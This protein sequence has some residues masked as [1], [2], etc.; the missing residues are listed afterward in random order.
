MRRNPLI[1]VIVLLAGPALAIGEPNFVVITLQPTGGGD[2]W[3]Y[4]ISDGHVVGE[5]NNRATL[6]A[7]LVDPVDLH[8]AGFSSSWA[9]GIS[10]GKQVGYGNPDGSTDHHALLWSGTPGSVVDLHPAGFSYSSARGISGDRQAGTG[11]LDGDSNSHALLWSGTPESVVDLHPAGFSHSCAYSISGDRQAGYGRLDGDSNNHALLWSGTPGSVVDLHPAGFSYSSA[12]GISGDSQAGLGLLDGDNNSHALLWSGTPESVVDLHPAGFRSSIATAISGAWQAGSGQKEGTSWYR[13]LF[14]S[15]TAES[16]VNLHSFVDEQYTSSQAYG[17]DS[18]GNVAGYAEIREPP[19]NLPQRDVLLWWAGG[20][21]TMR[22]LNLGKQGIHKRSVRIDSPKLLLVSNSLTVED[23][24]SVTLDGGSVAVGGTFHI[25]S[26]GSLSGHGVVT[27]AILGDG[28]SVI[29]ASGDTLELGDGNRLDGFSTSGRLEVGS[30]TVSLKSLSFSTLGSVTTLEGGT[31]Q[32]SKGLFLSGGGN[33]SGYGCINAMLA[34]GQGSNILASGNLQL[35][36]A[37]AFNGVDLEGA[38]TIGSHTVTLDDRNEA[39][40]GWHT[41]IGGGCLGAPNGLLLREGDTVAGYGM[42]TAD[43]TTQGYV[44]GE[45]PDPN[46]A[47][48]LSGYVTGRG[49]FGGNVIFSGTYDPGDSPAAVSLGNVAFGPNAALVIEIG[50]EQPGDGYDMLDVSGEA[51]L[52]GRL[53]LSVFKTCDPAIGDSYQIL[54]AATVRGRFDT[55]EGVSLGVARSL[56]V[57]YDSSPVTVTVAYPGDSDLDEDVD[58][59]DLTILGTY[60]NTPSG[61]EWSKADFDGDGDVDLDDLTLLGTYYN[62]VPGAPRGSDAIPEPASAIVLLVG[63]LGMVAR[64]R[65][66]QGH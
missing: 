56:A 61:M 4:G 10:G 13:A 15:G 43:L 6:W 54:T 5:S 38:L 11:R 53:T 48:E 40:L 45:G 9:R 3:G 21:V 44:H 55:V 25:R 18:F 1:S 57:T 34:S 39:V 26:D 31:L 35:G 41:A 59:D 7:D 52:A 36:D 63:A 20:P 33:I 28:S 37:N 62:Q 65:R 12:S 23:G 60:Y 19:E 46:D 8:P 24:A 58:L 29:S 27:G 47:L 2:N 42:V 30:C 17:I 64:A 32:A 49:N 51:T 50:G 22:D 16:A 66:R 14:W